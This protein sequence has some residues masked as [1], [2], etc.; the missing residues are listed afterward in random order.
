MEV[1]KLE[2]KVTEGARA[3]CEPSVLTSQGSCP[4]LRASFQE[5]PLKRMEKSRKT[6]LEMVLQLQGSA[7][8]G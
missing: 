1:V 8:P 2:M 3:V 6:R 7:R 4:S 5:L